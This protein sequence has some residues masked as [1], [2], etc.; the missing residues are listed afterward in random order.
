MLKFYKV[1][2]RLLGKRSVTT[3]LK[4]LSNLSRKV[5]FKL[6]KQ[7]VDFEWSTP[8]EPEWF[9]HFCDQFYGFR[10]SQN[11]LWVERGTFSLLAI[12]DQSNLLELCCGDGFN[13]YH[14]YSIRA[15]NMIAV[16]FDENAIA[17]AKKFNQSYNVDFRL[18]DIRNG[19]PEGKF[20]NIVWDAAIEHFTPEEI[21]TILN[22]IKSRLTE[23]GILSGY[24]IKEKD[25]G[26][27]S[28]NHH[29]YEFRSKEDLL[30][31]FTP[32]FKNVKV[33]ETVYPS[34]HN[35]YFYASDNIL[36]FDENWPSMASFKSN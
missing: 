34:R 30:R 21:N 11:P 10:S 22:T 23:S 5:A 18:V 6:H 26:Q 29:E 2:A 4:S 16:D 35:L 19:I 3:F 31:F 12:K 15:K 33:F 24:T 32:Y 1:I 14:F 25:T 27:K 7:Q 17:H 8:P 28:L 9:D 36:P 13:S 20:D